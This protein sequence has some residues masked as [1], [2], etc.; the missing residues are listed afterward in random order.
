MKTFYINWYGPFTH[1][2][3][4]DAFLQVAP[5]ERDVKEGLRGYGL[6]AWTGI[7][8]NVNGPACLQY[9]GVT[10][11]AYKWR[12][13]A[14]G[15]PQKKLTNTKQVWLG[16]VQSEWATRGDLEDAEHVLIAKCLPELNTE[17]RTL[18]NF[19]CAVISKFF[20]KDMS[21]PCRPVP[22][23][24]RTIPDVVI[25]DLKKVRYQEKLKS[26]APERVG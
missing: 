20:E 23:I 19:A 2:N 1:Q 9:I 10:E 14:K 11:D 5:I 12:F 17:K 21:R 4:V 16:K 25:W 7:Q 8:K 24:I 22:S 3:I 13:Q 26:Y 15:H 6:Y 18:P